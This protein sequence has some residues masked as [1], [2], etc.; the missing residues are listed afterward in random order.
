MEDHQEERARNCESNI[1]M[2]GC[3]ECLIIA[4]TIFTVLYTKTIESSFYRNFGLCYK[5]KFK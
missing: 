4:Y 3:I 1:Q 2:Y 5:H